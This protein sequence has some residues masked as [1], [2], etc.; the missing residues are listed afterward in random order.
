MPHEYV[1]QECFMRITNMSQEYK[2][3]KNELLEM[4]VHRPYAHKTT[5]HFDKGTY[6][7]EGHCMFQPKNY[8]NKVNSLYLSSVKYILKN[9]SF[10]EDIREE[11]SSSINDYIRPVKYKYTVHL[12][13]GRKSPYTCMTLEIEWKIGID[14]QKFINE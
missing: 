6:K 13:E 3:S 8:A 4:K 1:Q 2:I 11:Q 5:Y 9:N 10:T 12:Y 7:T 14:I